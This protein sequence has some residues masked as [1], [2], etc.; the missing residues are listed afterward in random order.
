MSF[1]VTPTEDSENVTVSVN[2][3]TGI[4]ELCDAASQDKKVISKY[5]RRS[6]L[7]SFYN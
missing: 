1:Y 6:I 3:C 7:K 5:L 2:V 4:S